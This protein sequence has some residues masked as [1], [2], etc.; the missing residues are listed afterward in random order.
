[1][2]KIDRT[3]Q[4]VNYFFA[5]FVQF[6]GGYPTTWTGDITDYEEVI[7]DCTSAEFSVVRDKF[8]KSLK[9]GNKIVTIKQ[10]SVLGLLQ[11]IVLRKCKLA[12]SGWP[13]ATVCVQN[14]DD[15]SM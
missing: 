14:A 6:I 9:A 10:V 11:Q 1:M 4:P 13:E 7:L 2:N 8:I 12:A 3:N 5:S 15:R